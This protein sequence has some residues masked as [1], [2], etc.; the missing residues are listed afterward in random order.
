MMESKPKTLDKRSY[1]FEVVRPVWLPYNDISHQLVSSLISQ[2]GYPISGPKTQKY[3]V[4]L[5]SLLKASQSHMLRAKG[6]R[7]HYLGIQ[8]KASA[9]SRYPLVGREISQKVVDDF[10]THFGGQKVEGSGTRGWFQ[11]DEGKWQ[12]DPRMTMYTL[13]KERIPEQLPEARFIEVGRP[14]V[15]VNEAETRP[16]KRARQGDK[17]SKGF[18]NDKAAKALDGAAYRASQRRVQRLNDYYLSHPLELPNGHAAASV[19][20]V[21]HDGRFDAGGRLYGAWTGLDQKDQRI[22]CTIDGEP[23]VEID[24]RASQPTLLSSLLGYKLG[25]LGPGD[26]WVD[27][28]GELS[29]LTNVNHY[30]T[31]I[32]DRI[33]KIEL[34]KRNRNTAKAVIMAVIGSGLPLKSK[35]PPEIMEKSGLTVSGWNNFRDELL[36]T[37]PALNELEPRY[38][39][40]GGLDGYING[41]GFLSYHESEMTLLT[42]DRLIEEDIP[43]FSVHDCIISKVTD[44]IRTAEVFRKT[45][46]EYCKE[47]SGLDVMVPLSLTT[48][49]QRIDLLPNEDQIRGEY[50]N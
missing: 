41:A 7:P 23:V 2:F 20:R 49:S 33:D 43:V 4:V 31:V 44:A 47:L 21:F 1:H 22:H 10:I 28:Y 12:L 19:T 50:L 11:N 34:M 36:I 48:V 16:Q 27:V 13:D 6:K 26:T 9:W 29:G 8:R 45:I 18:L 14:L 40:K 46:N 3:A 35:A 24:I 30:W 39:K 37:V 32:D 25:G 42:L 17:L 15:K 38:D 5:A